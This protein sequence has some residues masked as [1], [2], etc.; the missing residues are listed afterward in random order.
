MKFAA[1][2]W[3]AGSILGIGCI[4]MP[5]QLAAGNCKC[6]KN[7]GPGGG[8][9]CAQDQIATCDP[10]SGECNCTCDSV[11]RGK[12]K[13]DYQ[14][15]IFSKVLHTTV[16]STELSSPQYHKFVSTFRKGEDKGTF[17]FDKEVGA[18]KAAQV[19]VGVPEWLEGVLGGKGPM[20]FGPGSSLQNCPNGICIGGDNNGS[21]TVTN[22]YATPPDLK[23]SQTEETQVAETLGDALIGKKISIW[24]NQPTEKTRD[25]AAK[26]KQALESGGAT[27]NDAGSYIPPGGAIIHD[28][29][30]FVSVPKK[31]LAIANRIAQALGAAGVIKA[32]VP[33]LSVSGE[34]H[35]EILVNR[36]MET[37][38]PQ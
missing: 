14:A 13:D 5:M 36:G 19:K 38:P 30:S 24:L 18:G 9:R 2:R 6:P 10:S 20:S 7:P 15:L 16:D 25:F 29:I 27:M 4:V 23:M 1:F 28:G 33:V 3:I 11:E 17:L 21:A 34:E 37:A 26:L 22:N 32:N 31:D 35:I 8:V 12:S